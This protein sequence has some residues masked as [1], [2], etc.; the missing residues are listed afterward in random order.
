MVNS[1]KDIVIIGAG[2]TGLTI[3]ERLSEK[4]KGNVVVLEKEQ[5]IGGLAA[6]LSREGIFFDMGSHRL[7][8]K[9]SCKIIADIERIIGEKLL[10]RDRKGKMYFRNEFLSYP[11]D[12]IS[13]FKIL[14]HYKR[15]YRDYMKKLWGDD[16]DGVAMGVARRRKVFLNLRLGRIGGG[17]DYYLYPKDGIGSIS[18]KLSENIR[19][20]ES[21]LM[22]QAN[23]KSVSL[24]QGR[25]TG[26]DV[27]GASGL[28]RHIEPRILISTAPI[29]DIFS[30][31]FA[32]DRNISGL[33]WRG[34]ILL[35]IQVAEE[36]RA[37]NETYYIPESDMTI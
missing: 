5:F 29:D 7:H 14:P 33:R 10:K 22:T 27:E 30:L 35:Y 19:R 18:K 25:I 11:P 1:S 20:N 9:V 21:E 6:T 8:R 37:E 4:Y 26:M 2:I 34:L 36:I 16:S 28:C 32:G 17:R 23:I 31:V 15:L 12:V 13:L 3:A 24:E